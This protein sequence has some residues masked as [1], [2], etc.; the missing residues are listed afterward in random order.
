MGKGQT[1]AAG[2]RA[3]SALETGWND[4]EPWG[5]AWAASPLPS[6][7]PSPSTILH[8]LFPCILIVKRVEK[9]KT[10]TKL[11]PQFRGSQPPPVKC[12]LPCRPPLNHQH[13][14]EGAQAPS[15]GSPKTKSHR[16]RGP[17]WRPQASDFSQRLFH[18]LYFSREHESPR[19][20]PEDLSCG[21]VLRWGAGGPPRAL[22]SV[23]TGPVSPAINLWGKR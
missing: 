15:A 17:P 12:L 18:V 21:L 22:S 5:P 8:G 10:A 23:R 6:S 9:S 11:G 14:G 20:L 16:A 1:P 3:E 4:V 13:W 19:T 2:P 7:V